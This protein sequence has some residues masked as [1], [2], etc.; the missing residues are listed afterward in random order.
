MYETS[1]CRCLN[2]PRKPK[3]KRIFT[4]ETVVQAKLNAF[5]H[6]MLPHENYDSY[7]HNPRTIT[8]RDNTPRDEKRQKVYPNGKRFV[9][10][11]AQ[12]QSDAQGVKLYCQR[13]MTTEERQPEDQQISTP[14]L[15][16]GLLSTKHINYKTNG[17]LSS[18]RPS[19]SRLSLTRAVSMPEFSPLHSRAQTSI[20]KRRTNTASTSNLRPSTTT[21]NPFPMSKQLPRA[22][23]NPATSSPI[24]L[25]PLKPSVFKG[26]AMLDQARPKTSGNVLFAKQVHYDDDPLSKDLDLDSEHKQTPSQEPNTVFIPHQTRLQT[27]Q[28]WELP[29]NSMTGELDHFPPA[30]LNSKQTLALVPEF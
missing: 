4:K 10:N 29:D 23:F 20:S 21:S 6:Q 8:F 17:D 5:R 7:G 22:S 11:S 30:P 12:W 14:R 3:F 28:H 1:A 15:W 2:D 13:Y 9:L 25:Q 27:P 19:L 26:T 16:G 18:M 24:K